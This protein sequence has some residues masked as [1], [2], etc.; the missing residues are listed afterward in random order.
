MT[1]IAAIM[2]AGAL[3]TAASAQQQLYSYQGEK[4][5]LASHTFTSRCLG[6]LQGVPK[7]AYQGID[8]WGDYAVS[9][10]N[11]GYATI[12]KLHDGSFSRLSQFPLG[13]YSKYNHANVASFTHQLYAPGDP[14]PLLLVSQCYKTPVDG[15]KDLIYVERIASDMKSSQLVATIN[16]VDTSHLCGYAVQWVADNANNM[17]Y[18]FANTVSNL[19]PLNQHRI[20]KFRLPKLTGLEPGAEI[21]LTE[22]DML[23]NYLVEATYPYYYKQIGQGL[24]VKD[25]LLYMPVGLG[26]QEHPS[27][28][29][30]WDLTRHVMR[31]AIDMSRATRG[32]LEDCALH[33]GKLLMQT[34]GELYEIG[35]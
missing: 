31:N 15:K 16:F 14:F 5:D 17:L 12:Y 9:L 21:K 6:K 30:V 27:I 10:Q 3:C 8:T 22:A 1:T 28:L 7:Q 2:L 20:I 26:T 35:F 19:D 18:G 4:I 33:D 29:Y 23:E 24:L 25:G 32:E 34:Q 11:T 13:S